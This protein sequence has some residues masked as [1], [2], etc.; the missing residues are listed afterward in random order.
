[1]CYPNPFNA[2]TVIK[3][4]VQAK[5]A[6]LEI[7]DIAGKRV[8]SFNLN[9][10]FGQGQIIWDGTNEIGQKV[11]SGLYFYRLTASGLSQVEKMLL[12]R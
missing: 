9:D 1:M 11:S 8:K 5:Q 4:K 12:L 6:K 3:F 2:S 10:V 7:F